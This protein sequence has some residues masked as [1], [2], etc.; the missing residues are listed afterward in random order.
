MDLTAD[1]QLS[2]V[3]LPIKYDKPTKEEIGSSIKYPQNNKA[4][5][6]DDISAE[7]LKTDNDISVELFYPLF[8]EIWENTCHQ[9]YLIKLPEKG[10]LSNYSNYRG[11]TVLSVSG[12]FFDRIILKRMKGEVDTYLRNEEA[13]F[14]PQRSCIAQIVTI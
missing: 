11:N 5:G 12:K 4:T 13:G 14:R 2:T 6:P 3:N 7:V 1:I 10:E 9:G 8:T